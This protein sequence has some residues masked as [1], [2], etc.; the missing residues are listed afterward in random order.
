MKLKN[1]K[2]SIILA[3]AI[4]TNASSQSSKWKYHN[5]AS[6]GQCAI[7]SYVDAAFDASGNTYALGINLVNYSGF[8]FKQGNI[9]VDK[10]NS[11]GNVTASYDYDFD[12]LEE[13]DYPVQLRTDNSSN[14]YVLANSHGYMILIKLNSSL[15]YQWEKR[16]YGLNPVTIGVGSK[17]VYVTGNT[18]D[19]AAVL[20]YAQSNG[21][22][23]SYQLYEG[24]TVN[25]GGVI[26]D[27]YAITGSVGSSSNSGQL[28]VQR[29]DST[30][31]LKW[32]A[33]FNKVN[34]N[35]NDEG[36]QIKC[37]NDNFYVGGVTN[38]A[39]ASDIGLLVKFNSSGIMQWNKLIS[40]GSGAA[41][42][43]SFGKMNVDVYNE[44]VYI[45]GY[46]ATHRVLKYNNAGTKLWAKSIAISGTDATNID[47]IAI[48]ATSSV[49]SSKV[50]L[51]G[52][53]KYTVNTF[54][55]FERCVAYILNSS[56]GSFAYSDYDEGGGFLYDPSFYFTRVRTNNK[57]SP[58]EFVALGS[59]WM[60]VSNPQASGSIGFA[61]SY[62]SISGPMKIASDEN[63]FAIVPNPAADEITITL[64]PSFEDITIT[65][66]DGKSVKSVVAKSQTAII[67][68]SDLPAGV[69]FVNAKGSTGSLNKKFMKK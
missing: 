69:Y 22:W 25:D 61:D 48:D 53:N 44:D 47:D 5:V 13:E 58:V 62:N 29:Y 27:G 45:T 10:L 51:V 54:Q 65:T 6:Y 57:V 66:A 24:A 4:I 21:T 33:K 50:C 56:N 37:V 40:V 59:G 11:S 14:V 38:N 67:N 34:G 68:I 15:I 28:F 52:Q 1:F 41:N 64:P 31:S 7:N 3:L 16:F 20:R 63:D 49:A 46:N 18:G 42:Y 35:Y 23:L 17:N 39:S 9:H 26:P 60:E 19:G 30:L 55:H 2:L 8:C 36:K 12:N 43:V 32:T